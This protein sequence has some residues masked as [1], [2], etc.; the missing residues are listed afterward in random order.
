MT[1]SRFRPCIDLH[2]GQV[3]QIVGG[4]LRDDD[5]SALTTNFVANHPPSYFAKLYKENNLIGGHVI[6]LGPGNDDA[7]REALQAWPNGFQLGGGITN[8]NADQW[9]DAGADKV[10][11]TS[12]LFPSAK[13]DIE[14][15]RRLSEKVE[16]RCLVIDVSCRKKGNSW[17][18]AKN[19]WQDLTDLE[20]NEESLHEL[21]DFC[22]EFLVHAADV[23]GLCRGIDE[24]L[25]ERLGQWCKIPTTYAGGAKSIYDL[26]LVDR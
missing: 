10:I 17:I 16:K 3:K 2:G 5:A 14:R 8:I 21:Q 12:F 18:V 26:S 7:A 15:L 11:V 24:S 19:R 25:V 13:F 9:L 1:R 20:V 4:T 6:K 22:S 23:E